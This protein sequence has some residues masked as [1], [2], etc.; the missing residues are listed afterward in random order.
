MNRIFMNYLMTLLLLI[1]FFAHTVRAETLN[2]TSITSL[3]ATINT[4]GVFCLT[5]NLGTN[6]SSGNAIYITAN[7]VTL[8]LNGWKVGGQAAGTGTDAYGIYIQRRR[9]R[10]H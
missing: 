7:N 3:P 1:G 6:I 5:G 9:Q 4:Q 10:H 8:D 2:C